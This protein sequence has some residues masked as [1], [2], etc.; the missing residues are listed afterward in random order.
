[1]QTSFTKFDDVSLSELVWF[2]LGSKK[3]HQVFYAKEETKHELSLVEH[4]A[5]PEIDFA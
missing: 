2:T 3:P 5:I 4:N 1:M